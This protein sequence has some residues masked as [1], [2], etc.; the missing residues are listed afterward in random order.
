LRFLC[1][2]AFTISSPPSL[3]CFDSSPFVALGNPC[4][5]LLVGLPASM[6]NV[7]DEG[8]FESLR[9]GLLCKPAGRISG[10]VSVRGKAEAVA[11]RTA[12]ALFDV[13]GKSVGWV[14]SF[15]IVAVVFCLL[16][17]GLDGILKGS[18]A[19][20]LGRDGDGRSGMSSSSSDVYASVGS[21]F[22]FCRAASAKIFFAP[23]SLAA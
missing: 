6:A 22:A 21:H 7:V 4:I 11:A 10:S 18:A 23:A 14:V 15:C 13:D 1:M 5:C 20:T 19:V 8:I 17:P 12:A 2:T 9:L 16:G 3:P